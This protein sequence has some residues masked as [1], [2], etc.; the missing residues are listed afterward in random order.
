MCSTP[1]VQNQNLIIKYSTSNPK[2]C[3][4]PYSGKVN[5]KT[6]GHLFITNTKN[7]K[8]HNKGLVTKLIYS[9]QLKLFNFNTKTVFK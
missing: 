8:P 3:P 2:K 1:T 6:T 5:K 4:H 9:C 7:I